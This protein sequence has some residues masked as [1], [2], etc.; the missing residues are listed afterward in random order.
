L[1]AGGAA[2]TIGIS[3]NGANAV[4]PPN[5][6]RI[7]P[8]TPAD[9]GIILA[10]IRALADYEQLLHEVVATESLVANT[11]FGERPIA[12]VAIAE[13]QGSPA[14]FAL[15]FHNYSTFLARPGIY[16]EDLFVHPEFRGHGIGKSLLCHLASLAVARN[17]GRLDWSVLDWNEPAMQFYRAI[18]ARPMPEWIK[19]RLDGQ[20][21]LDVA[22]RSPST[23]TP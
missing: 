23:F 4:P 1:R 13:W 2:G 17:C 18:G 16:L 22:T 20:A 21:L 11:L 15:F 5:P 12:E 6:L 3:L 10:F 19:F 14:G 7:R 9:S 8:A